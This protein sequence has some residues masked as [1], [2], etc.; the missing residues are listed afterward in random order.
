[1]NGANL[2]TENNLMIGNKILELIT[3]MREV[4]LNQ[5]VNGV[6][7]HCGLCAS[8]EHFTDQ[9]P[10]LQEVS[11]IGTELVAVIYQGQQNAFRQPQQAWQNQNQGHRATAES[12][13]S[14][15]YFRMDS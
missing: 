14:N 1:M 5:Q 8:N 9:C 13:F 7:K 2:F 3:L 15:I 11:N 4:T 10:Q 12:F 6:A